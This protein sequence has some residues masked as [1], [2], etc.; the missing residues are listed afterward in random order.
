MISRQKRCTDLRYR[1]RPE[2]HRVV[3]LSS[4]KPTNATPSHSNT[5][6]IV[7]HS[8][9]LEGDRSWESIRRVPA[10]VELSPKSWAGLH[11]RM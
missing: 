11:S 1:K 9:I 3:S 6:P 7:T 4:L 5:S 8:G 2:P 10:I